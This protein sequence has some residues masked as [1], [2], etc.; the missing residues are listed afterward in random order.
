MQD[1]PNTYEYFKAACTRNSKGI[2]L[3]A[4]VIFVVNTALRSKGVNVHMLINRSNF[5]AFSIVAKNPLKYSGI[6]N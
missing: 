1:C 6:G 5:G 2:I 4:S 3:I